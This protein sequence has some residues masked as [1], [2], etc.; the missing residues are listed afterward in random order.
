MPTQKPTRT[1]SQQLKGAQ[2][3]GFAAGHRHHI[4]QVSR[5]TL[6]AGG[7]H[8]KGV[9]TKLYVTV[10]VAASDRKGRYGQAAEVLRQC[11]LRNRLLFPGR[12]FSG[13]LFLSAAFEKQA[14]TP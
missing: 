3:R 11:P 8:G 13:A 5:Q 2:Y 7:M 9:A 14:G 10:G 12:A 6:T 4:R 1:A